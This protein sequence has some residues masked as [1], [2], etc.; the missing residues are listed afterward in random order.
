MIARY[1]SLAAFLLLV[2]MTSLVG[3]TFEAG[4]WYYTTMRQ[5][6]W[7][8]PGWF[9]IAAWTLVYLS[10]ALA[11]WNAWLTGH[12]SRIGAL[13]WWALLLVLNV[14]WFAVFYGLHR[15]GYAL[16]V[17][18]VMAVF[19]LFCMRAF[20]MLSRQAVYLMLPYI[21]WVICL[22]ALNLA[23]WSFNGG[24]LEHLFREAA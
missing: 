4:E 17:L 3:S 13:T 10:M 15:P 1:F 21:F 2:T 5:P 20:S 23:I 22:W 8:P 7:W 6:S 24:I 9:F 11:A 14:G 19:A 12:Y 16:L 18:T